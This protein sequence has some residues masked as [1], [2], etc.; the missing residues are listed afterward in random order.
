MIYLSLSETPFK[1]RYRNHVRDFNDETHNNRTKVSKYVSDLK[2]NN[3]EP[4]ITWTI[5]FKIYGTPK[6][7]FCRLCLKKLLIIKFSN[8]YILLKK[9][10]EFIS[11]CR[12]ENQNLIVNVK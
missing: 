8:Q 6:R 3:K 5:I 7:D 9:R 2:Q 10:S 12:H 1:D 11:K 4:H